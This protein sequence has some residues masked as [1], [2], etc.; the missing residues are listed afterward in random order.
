[1][2]GSETP[3]AERPPLAVT[4]QL[5]V[6]PQAAARL[7][8][9]DAVAMRAFRAADL[10]AGGGHMYASVIRYLQTDMAPRLFG[11]DVGADDRSLFTAAAALTEMAAFL[12]ADPVS[13]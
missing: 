11:S 1:M 3:P 8:D 7:R 2:H 10:Q 12:F 13:A 9:P 4:R 5:Q 6:G